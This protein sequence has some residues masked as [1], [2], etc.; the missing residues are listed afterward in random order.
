LS[1]IRRRLVALVVG[2]AALTPT[3]GT[4][5]ANA[6]FFVGTCELQVVFHFNESIGFATVG[7]PGYWLEVIPLHGGLMPCQITDKVLDPLRDTGITA[8]GSSSIFNCEAAFG[9]GGWSQSWWHANG[10]P[11]PAPVN[12]GRHTVA[13][14]WDNWVIEAQGPNPVNFASVIPLRADPGRIGEMAAK[15]SNGSLWELYTIGT[16]VFQDPTV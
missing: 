3:I 1:G 2:V 9:G 5:P 8:S 11:S 13:G 7:N 6:I 4:T 10:S 14:T 12:S 15:C 16:Q